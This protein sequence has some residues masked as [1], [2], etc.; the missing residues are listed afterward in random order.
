MTTSTAD[1]RM[2]KMKPFG[3]GEVRAPLSSRDLPPGPRWPTLVQSIALVRFRHQFVPAMHKRY[4]DEFTVRIMP[5]G[6]ALVLFTRPEHAK[7]IFAGDPEVF[8]A[9]KGNAILGPIMGEHSLLLQDGAQ[10]KRAR[11][12]LMPAFNGQALRGYRSLVEEVAR[13]EVARWHPGEE[14]R[15]LDRMNALTLEVILRVV[16]GVTDE[17][18]LS[19][20]RP[21]VNRTVN[22]SPAILLGWGYPKLQKYGPWKRTVDNQHELDRLMYAEIRERRTAPDL[23]DRTDV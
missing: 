7:E 2:A 22:I 1:D 21:R 19:E 4:G 13:A 14:F 9:G 5:K 18:R 23:A 11:A 16:F 12:L 3:A 17:R 6:S 10:H 20:L 8:H 15:S